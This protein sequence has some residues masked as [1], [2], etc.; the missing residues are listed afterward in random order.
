M[1][2]PEDLRDIV[3]PAFF[4]QPLVENAVRHGISPTRA[5][6]TV[7]VMARI[8]EE[9]DDGTGVLQ[10]TVQDTGA[11]AAGSDRRTA[12]EGIG[13]SNVERRL[14]LAYGDRA[15]L[16]FACPAG[17]GARVDVRIPFDTASRHVARSTHTRVST[18]D[19]A[20]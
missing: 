11:G 8:E 17:R 7:T 4:L 3:V 6:G 18:P 15:S 20:S 19:V 1:D 12:G 5:G 2:V 14:A 13:L 10:V 9:A 16:R